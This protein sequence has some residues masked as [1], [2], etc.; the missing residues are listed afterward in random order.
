MS[1]NNDLE[2]TFS[3]TLKSTQLPEAIIDVAEMT[4]D[5]IIDNKILNNIPVVKTFV[6]LTQVSINIHDKLFLKK[7]LTFLNGVGEFEPTKREEMISKI[8]TS[9]KF[10][11]KVGEKL[12][13]ILDS[14]SDYESAELIAK[15]FAA[16]LCGDIQYSDY[17]EASEVI[18]RLSKQ[19]LQDFIKQYSPT[20]METESVSHLLHTGL[21][22]IVYE[23]IEV[24]VSK[25]EPGDW[26]D[27][28]EDRYSA[29]VRGGELLISPTSAGHTIFKVLASENRKNTLKEKDGKKRGFSS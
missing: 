1:K 4:I 18:A 29:D 5:S 27:P 14:C 8:D 23:E 11:L 16:F 2:E 26:K 15:L 21:L 20:H 9:K 10:R 22:S 17:M 24:D 13:Y 28:Q 19:D 12:L 3:Q 7:I 6:G 25:D